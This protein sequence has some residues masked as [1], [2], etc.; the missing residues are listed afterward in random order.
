M[1]GSAGA[2]FGST[3]VVGHTTPAGCLDRLTAVV[4]GWLPGSTELTFLSTI[5]VDLSVQ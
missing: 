3:P 1:P 5:S 2:R 4:R